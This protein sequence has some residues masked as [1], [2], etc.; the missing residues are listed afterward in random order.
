MNT[1]IAMVLASTTWVN[2]KIP[3][4]PVSELFSGIQSG[5]TEKVAWT[6]KEDELNYVLLT[7]TETGTWSFI[8]YDN[9]KACFLA[10]GEKS[11]DKE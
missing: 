5:Y 1:L 6:A 9:K 11:G 10:A 8:G 4:Q 2:I 3:C 7:N